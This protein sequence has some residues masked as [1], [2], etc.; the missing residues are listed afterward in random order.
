MLYC[1]LVWVVCSFITAEKNILTE[2]DLT[3]IGLRCQ[4]IT[5]D[6]CYNFVCLAALQLATNQNSRMYENHIDLFWFPAEIF[7]DKNIV[8]RHLWNKLSNNGSKNTCCSKIPDSQSVNDKHY[9]TEYEQW[10][11][12]NWPNLWEDRIALI[13]LVHIYVR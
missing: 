1:G 8:S 11:K 12:T 5:C 3:I 9:Q 10:L 7:L 6:S 2:I 13:P 4:K